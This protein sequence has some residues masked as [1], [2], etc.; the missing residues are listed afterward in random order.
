MMMS[1]KIEDGLA[2][3]LFEFQ[4]LL[5]VPHGNKHNITNSNNTTGECSKNT[6][7]PG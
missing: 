6:N 1:H 2:L 5:Y 4:I 7:D 3:E